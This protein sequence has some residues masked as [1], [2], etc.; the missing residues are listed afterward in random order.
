MEFTIRLAEILGFEPSQ[1]KGVIK[2]ICDHTGLERHLVAALLHG[3]TRSINMHALTKICDFL[4]E[5]KGIAPE[6]L[7][8]ILF[9]R[10]A[11]QFWEVLACHQSL[12]MVFGIRKASAW[13]EE[14]FVS[15][16]DI[17]L[18]ADLLHGISSAAQ[19]SPIEGKIGRPG[20]SKPSSA[21]GSQP[22][23]K[24]TSKR[25]GPFP[26]HRLLLEQRFVPS[27]ERTFARN[28]LLRD[29]EPIYQEFEKRK[30]DK[31]L[32]CLG[33]IK[34]NPV[35]ELVLARTFGVRPFV[36]QDEVRSVRDRAC[37]IF[38]RYRE[39]DM[40]PPSCCGGWKLALRHRTQESGIYYE[41]KTGKWICCPSTRTQGAALVFYAYHP[42]R[43]RLES[44]IGGF[45]G[46][47]TWY[48]ARVLSDHATSFW[49]P[50]YSSDDLRVGMFI[51]QF[52]YRNVESEKEGI[53]AP[54]QDRPAKVE[55]ISLA[56]E[57]LT[58]RLT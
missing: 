57:A 17:L 48:V 50:S 20:A 38:F 58:R 8:G 9:G 27:P 45:S 47:D 39:R 53:E 54:P 10:M 19:A 26:A 36:S 30:G 16:A 22:I 55:V 51:M 49:P 46:R 13:P 33:S 34:S 37:P 3:R 6:D 23:S 5:H 7:P 24:S 29:A 4:I 2:E 41:T 40:T 11:N 31:T 15:A 56:G 18:Q 44:V 43:G 12:A 21:K 25:I 52:Q 1:R 32:I 28:S 35:I 42:Q 14:R